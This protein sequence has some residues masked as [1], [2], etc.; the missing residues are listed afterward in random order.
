MV[1]S[2]GISFVVNFLGNR[3]YTR[4]TVNAE[5]MAP[6]KRL[7]IMHVT[8]LLGAWSVMLFEAHV[9]AL[10]ALSVLKII[11]DVHGHLAERSTPSAVVSRSSTTPPTKLDVV[12]RGF[13]AFL[14]FRGVVLAVG[15][16]AEAYRERIRSE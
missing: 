4:T 9:G 10:I 6:W 14:V 7:F 5:V 8:T 1:V 3:E 15:T 16:G 11:V 13:G 12:L 2:H